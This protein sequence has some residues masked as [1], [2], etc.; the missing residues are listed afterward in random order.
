VPGELRSSIRVGP[1]PL[2]LAVVIGLFAMAGGLILGWALWAILQVIPE[3]T[4]SDL[5]RALGFIVLFALIVSAEVGAALLAIAYMLHRHSRAGRVLAYVVLGLIFTSVL[6]GG[7]SSGWYLFAMLLT[8]GGVVV[9]AL[10]PAVRDVFTGPDAP[11]TEQPT[12]VVVARAIA[13]AWVADSVILGS[14]YFF[15][16]SFVEGKYAAYGLIGGGIAFGAYVVYRRLAVA[17]PQAR[18]FASVVAGIGIVLG[19]LGIDPAGFFCGVVI[20]ICVWAP[21]GARQWFTSPAE[22]IRLSR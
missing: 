3:M 5:G 16:G 8:G 22:A 21:P 20:L 4:E 11:E 9:L 12:S 18:V 10:A 6:L 15:V 13:A 19:L 17:D 1:H 14:V 7:E 2:E